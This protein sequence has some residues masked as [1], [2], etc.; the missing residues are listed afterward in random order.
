MLNT[1]FVEKMMSESKAGG[2]KQAFIIEAIYKY[3]KDVMTC[4]PW[5]E[6]HMINFNAWKQCA[7]ECIQAIENRNQKGEKK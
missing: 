2:L 4:K 1:E 5:G 6:K 3:S 7:A